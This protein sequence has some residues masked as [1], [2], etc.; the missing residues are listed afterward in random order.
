MS[1]SSFG[2][3]KNIDWKALVDSFERPK[4]SRLQKRIQIRL[5]M[6][7]DLF[8]HGFSAQ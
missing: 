7:D 5:D 8:S 1:W 4:A 2:S 6:L 3:L